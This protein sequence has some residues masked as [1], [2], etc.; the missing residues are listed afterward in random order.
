MQR[1]GSALQTVSTPQAVLHA[2]INEFG[3]NAQKLH[4]TYTYLFS[5]AIT[6][7]VK[8]RNTTVVLL[9][10]NNIQVWQKIP[11]VPMNRKLTSLLNNQQ[12]NSHTYV[13]KLKLILLLPHPRDNALQLYRPTSTN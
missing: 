12:I 8:L 7:I 9:Q 11:N 13:R 6:V 5:I 3:N 4:T 2:E 1:T 10:C